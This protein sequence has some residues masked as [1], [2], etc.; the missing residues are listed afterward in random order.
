MSDI[1]VVE[2]Y[3]GKMVE[4]KTFSIS[5]DKVSKGMIYH[6]EFS[7]FREEPMMTLITDGSS[8]VLVLENE[9]LRVL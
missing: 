6:I 4:F 8:K 7:A 5:G 1:N 3:L 9:I 2:K